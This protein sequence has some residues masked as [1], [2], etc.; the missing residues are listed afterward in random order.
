[1]GEY[2]NFADAIYSEVNTQ[3]VYKGGCLLS[4]LDL[5]LQSKGFTRVN[6][7]MTGAGWGDALYVR[8]KEV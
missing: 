2:I 6:I 1:M 5:F 4:D 8:D 7:S 3:E